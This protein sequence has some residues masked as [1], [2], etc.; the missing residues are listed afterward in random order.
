MRINQNIAA[1]SALRNLST[2]STHMQ[3]SL[4]RL[5]SGFR[6][7]R[8][9]DD[10]A[11]LVI[12]EGLRSQMGGLK[13]A[14]RNAQ[15]GIS[16]V[17]TAEGALTEVHSILQRM[18][19]L[20]VQANNTGTNGDAAVTAI[21][22]EIDQLAE[23]L[24]RISATTEFN[25][26]QLLDGNYEGTFQV[27]AGSSSDHQIGVTISEMSA[28]GLSVDSLDMTDATAAIDALDTAIDTVSAAR[29]ELGAVQN[30]FEHTIANLGVAIE[31]ISASE[32]RIRDTD[33]ADEM[34]KFTRHQIMVQ[35]GTAMLA[36]ANTS[37]QSVLALLR[38]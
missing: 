33:M 34:A 15:D 1:M 12:S 8:A 5:S 29:G 17:Q 19:D 28:S 13:V 30:R 11:G 20:S 21:Q 18:R 27:G 26:T 35:A 24:D 6:I 32:S 7:S 16:I 23:E 10:A 36:Q 2:N 9:A 14:S 38:G 31:N 4:D 25:G 37:T 22:D 3:K